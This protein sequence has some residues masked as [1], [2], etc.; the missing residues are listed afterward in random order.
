MPTNKKLEI[1]NNKK[2]LNKKYNKFIINVK[3]KH[4]QKLLNRDIKYNP[5][6]YNTFLKLS[7]IIKYP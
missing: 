5:K 4:T 3:Q 6:I 7:K 2:I 1:L